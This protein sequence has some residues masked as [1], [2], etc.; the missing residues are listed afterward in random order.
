MR[1]RVLGAQERLDWDGVL[2]RFPH[3]DVYFSSEYH[4]AHE[5][6]GDGT[7]CAF[8]AEEGDHVFFHPFLARP[9]RSVGDSPIE[10]SWFDLESV[11]GY[12]GPLCTTCDGEFLSKAW[13]SFAGWCQ[14]NHVI[15]EFTRFNPFLGNHCFADPDSRL[16]CDRETVVL[17]LGSS[18]L[19]LWGSYPSV[20]RNMVRKAVRR[21]LVCRNVSLDEGL[22]EFKRLYRETMARVEAREYFQ[23]SDA[24]Y[25]QLGQSL[26]ERVRLF[27]VEDM[28]RVVAAALFL[29]HEDRIHYHLAG[30]DSDY[31]EYAPNNLLI[32]TV[33]LWGQERGYRWLHL[34][35]G[36]TPSPRDSLYSF[37]ASMSRSRLP[38][39]VGRRVHNSAVYEALRSQ[40]MSEMGVAERPDYFLLYRLGRT[41]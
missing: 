24:Y 30:S 5:L 33:A 35:G 14:E 39:Y 17:S 4:R 27:V 34:G 26:G 10:A 28:D 9:I 18:E 40:W 6:N 12:S 31:R 2:A 3:T 13:G 41:D 1:W 25:G 16:T 19:E 22:M 23:F 21:G 38:F 8:V 36:R 20:Q 37:K 15:A 32:H 7:A 11:Y 29:V